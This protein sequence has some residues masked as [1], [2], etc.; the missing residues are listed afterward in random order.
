MATEFPAMTN[1]SPKILH[2][3]LSACPQCRRHADLEQVSAI[4]AAGDAPRRL[5]VP[6][7]RLI[8]R[9]AAP[10]PPA[11]PDDASAWSLGLGVG[12]GLAIGAAILLCLASVAPPSTPLGAVVVGGLAL[13]GGASVWLV[14][15]WLAV[16]A[17]RRERWDS[18]P[19]RARWQQASEVWRQ[20]V[21]CHRCAVVFVP[22]YS[23]MLPA[24][25][26]QAM[27][28]GGVEWPWR[29]SGAPLPA[30]SLTELS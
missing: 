9:L 13:L 8:Q 15:R 17:H 19:E 6:S 23:A 21:Y 3:T 16:A 5:P 12:L 7:L 30:R 24:A 4:V 20:L 1:T 26:V 28:T 11:P 29:N 27:L 14:Y 10:E 2:V 22:G 25:A 18:A